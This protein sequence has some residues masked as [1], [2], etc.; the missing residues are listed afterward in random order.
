MIIKEL[1]NSWDYRFQK[2]EVLETVIQDDIFRLYIYSDT[3]NI[4]V[5]HVIPSQTYR[6]ICICLFEPKF[7]QYTNDTYTQ[8]CFDLKTFN[9]ILSEQDKKHSNRTYWESLVYYWKWDHILDDKYKNLT[10][11]DYTKLEKNKI[12]KRSLARTIIAKWNA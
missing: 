12:I 1:L 8:D 7:Y 2:I 9:D 4:P 10:Q 3:L 6:D 11:P 5:F